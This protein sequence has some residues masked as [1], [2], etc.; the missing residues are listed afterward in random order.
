[1]AADSK[2]PDLQTGAARRHSLHRKV[3]LFR[4]TITHVHL[5]ILR[6]D[7]SL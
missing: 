3:S 2:R 5:V 6:P 4:R 1:M 7:P